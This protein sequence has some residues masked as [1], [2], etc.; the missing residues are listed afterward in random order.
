[1]FKKFDEFVAAKNQMPGSGKDLGPKPKIQ[2]VPDYTG[3][4]PKSPPGGG[5]P[6]VGK[7]VDSKIQPN[8]KKGE[9]LGHKDGGGGLYEPNAKKGKAAGA[10]FLKVK[11]ESFVSKTSRM[12]PKEFTAY[13]TSQSNLGA[14]SE[15]VTVVGRMMR[16]NPASIRSLVREAKRNGTFHALFQACLE[17]PEAFSEIAYLLG[18][19]EG[20][21]ASRKLVRAMDEAVAP[22]GHDMGPLLKKKMLP[23]PGEDG[24]NDPDD[25]MNSHPHGHPD[26]DNHNPFGG[27]DDDDMDD[28]DMDDDSADDGDD[29]DSDSDDDSTDDSDDDGADKDDNDDQDAG[30]GDDDNPL[31]DPLDDKG[32]T[33]RDDIP[34]YKKKNND[35]PRSSMMKRMMSREHT[36]TAA[37]NLFNSLQG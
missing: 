23:P 37:K 28:D 25:E 18:S 19:E 29:Y 4:I 6:Y 31:K 26:D 21:Q 32:M 16:N 7:G 17:Q 5:N 9:G 12:S 1:M 3:P 34:P 8:I 10:P 2:D 22:P 15:T 36:T 27:G 14:V 20:E 13:M 30:P 35:G 33:R 11:G 24:H